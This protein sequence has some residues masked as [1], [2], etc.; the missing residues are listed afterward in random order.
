MSN[1]IDLNFK[2]VSDAEGA[3]HIEFLY[4]CQDKEFQFELKNNSKE[5]IRI[6]EVILGN[7]FFPSNAEFFGEGY[8]MLSMYG[9]TLENP[10]SIGSYADATHYRMPQVDNGFIVYNLIQVNQENGCTLAA[11]TTCNAF[12]G[13]FRIYADKIQVVLCLEN[14]LLKAGN[15]LE[16]EKL[17]IAKGDIIHNLY[18]EYTTIVEQNHPKLNVKKSPTGWCS[19][20]CYGPDIT[21]DIM[22]ANISAIKEKMP[23]LEYLLIDDG[24]QSHMGDWLTDSDKLGT[25]MKALCGEIIN[26]GMKPAIWV[27]PFI[28]DGDSDLFKNHPDWFVKD[29]NGLPLC[30]EDVTFGGWRLNPWYMLDTSH[31]EAIEYLKT[32]FTTMKNEYGC[33]YFKL[34]A[35]N[36]GALPFGKRYKDCT[37]IEAYRMGMEAICEA[38]GEDGFVLGC[39]APL[40]PSLGLVHGMRV[41]TDISRNW[42]SIRQVAFECFRRQYQNGKFWMNDPDC[43]VYDE[44]HLK[45]FDPAGERNETNNMLLPEEKIFHLSAI[46]STAG[47]KFISDKICDWNNE[48]LE[49]FKKLFSINTEQL[50][51]V[52]NDYT[53]AYGYANN[54]KKV[55]MFFNPCD[56]SV[57]RS[58]PVTDDEYYRELWTDECMRC[59]CRVS[60]TIP[61]HSA[62][63]YLSDN[64]I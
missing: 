41:S 32:V 57:V 27:A 15:S 4:E 48:T 7:M 64:L 24:Y 31:P 54:G 49:K 9:G 63:I 28:A 58:M 39:N 21:V 23:E 2:A 5:D 20:Y 46:A 51:F 33:N 10:Q 17:Y 52:N 56:N 47:V 37:A 13:E 11:F 19:W 40:W 34:D 38:V 18:E 30:S 16:L 62:K 22:N 6:K 43:A 12:R 36:W 55:I 60:V 3:A 8:N 25:S 35:N 26:N 50:S 29:E 42:G 45:L 14:Y 53:V 1:L 44:L 61:A 59:E